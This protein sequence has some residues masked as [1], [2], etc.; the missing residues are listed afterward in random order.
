MTVALPM[1]IKPNE[2]NV[3]ERAK[4]A[5]A[6]SRVA[7]EKGV[8]ALRHKLGEYLDEARTKETLVAAVQDQVVQNYEDFF[9]KL[10]TLGRT[11]KGT[12]GVVVSSK[13][14]GREDAVWDVDTFAEWAEAVFQVGREGHVEDGTEDTDGGGSRTG[15]V[16]RSGSL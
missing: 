11:G 10:T 16:S 13:G 12:A 4:R 7:I 1:T 14:K 15:S 2:Q 6:A 9:E 3:D 8:P 5:V